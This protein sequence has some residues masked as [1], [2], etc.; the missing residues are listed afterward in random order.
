MFHDIQQSFLLIHFPKDGKV[1][2]LQPIRKKKKV[3]P[4]YYPDN[5]V[6]TYLALCMSEQS[7]WLKW[8]Y[9]CKSSMNLVQNK[10]E[11]CLQDLSSDSVLKQSEVHMVVIHI[12]FEPQ[13][14][15]CQLVIKLAAFSL[16]H[17][18]LFICQC[19]LLI[20]QTYIH[21]VRQLS[22]LSQ[23]LSSRKEKCI[24]WFLE[25]EENIACFLEYIQTVCDTFKYH[26]SSAIGHKL[27]Y[28]WVLKYTKS[29]QFVPK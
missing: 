28:K 8:V 7:H 26:K 15:T 4:G 11:F 16:F 29:D 13:I 24:A 2:W 9:M 3:F 1:S 19:K 10:Y 5:P 14:R 20:F 25:K 18:R 12:E 17:F 21:F 6:H 27:N 22:L 23:D